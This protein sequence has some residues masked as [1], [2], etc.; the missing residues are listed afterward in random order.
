MKKAIIIAICSL[1]GLILLAIAF[2]WGV[3]LYLTPDR[4]SS[5]INREMSGY[6]NADIKV[7]N[8]RFT[9]WSTF[10]R[11]T[12]E[13]DSVT[14]VS[15][16]LDSLPE[17]MT[18]KLPAD[19][20]HLASAR[21]MHGGINILRLLKGEYVMKDLEV[22]ELA[23]NIVAVN[24]SVNNYDILPH[25]DTEAKVPFFTTNLLSF[26]KTKGIK[27]YFAQ[28]DTHGEIAL[29]SVVMRRLETET[30]YDLSL[31]GK[32]SANIAGLTL[33]RNMPF[34]VDGNLNLDFKPFEI[35]FSDFDIDLKSVKSRLNMSVDLEGNTKINQLDYHISAVNLM[36]L[37]ESLPWLPLGNMESLSA[38]MSVE[39]TARLD[40]PYTFKSGELPWV[41]VSFDVPSGNIEYLAD[42][43]RKII[44][45]HDRMLA[46]F[47]F[48]GDNPKLSTVLLE[49]FTLRSEGAVLTVRGEMTDLLSSPKVNLKAE[50]S[51]A[52]KSLAVRFPEF[53]NMQLD[54][55]MKFDADAAFSLPS[56]SLKDLREGVKDLS[57]QAE[58]DVEN[59]HYAYNGYEIAAGQFH[60][61]AST[62]RV[63]SPLEAAGGIPVEF[64]AEAD[65]ASFKSSIGTLANASLDIKADM[66]LNHHTLADG[67]VRS[68]G[69]I[70]F[71]VK[72]GAANISGGIDGLSFTTGSLQLE[73]KS[74]GRAPSVG[75]LLSQPVYLSANAKGASVATDKFSCVSPSLKAS[76]SIRQDNGQINLDGPLSVEATD[77]TLN[78]SGKNRLALNKASAVFGEMPAKKGKG[79]TAAT[80]FLKIKADSGLLETALNDYANPISDVDIFYTPDSLAINN[81]GIRCKSSRADI[82]ATVV[83]L[84]DF[85][86]SDMKSPLRGNIDI[87]CD[88][89]NINQIART[90]YREHDARHGDTASSLPDTVPI[91]IPQNIDLNLS[92]SAKESVYTNLHLYNLDGRMK[93]GQGKVDVEN[94]S[95]DADFGHA[96]FALAYDTYNPQNMTLSANADLSDINVVEFFKKFHTLEL[97]MPEMSNLNGIVDLSLDANLLLFPDMYINMPSLRADIDLKGRELSL[98]QSDFIHRLARK[99][100]IRDKNNLA[101]KDVDIK[102]TVH[103]NLLELY[104][105]TLDVENYEL[106][107]LGTNNFDG[108]LYY[109]IAVDKS[110]VPFRFG[111]DVEGNFRNPK[112]R[113]GSARF[114]SRKGERITLDNEGAP[115]MNLVKEAKFFAREFVRKAAESKDE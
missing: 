36:R 29:D 93:V 88:T 56:L 78:F 25:T 38:D 48:N 111:V 74:K 106:R 19:A 10:P 108:D 89:I 46:D 104:P 22:A 71:D 12:L 91:L 24:D 42:D 87:A 114:N 33:L 2:L 60:L 94:F 115:Q 26:K 35:R 110:P 85:I 6:F 90:Y 81:L 23:L 100:F 17:A 63:D 5:I 105:F 69:N 59:A 72:A 8:P 84:D 9:F 16:T 66:A 39:V 65:N 75:A 86:R 51:T 92:F 28:T 18:K 7:A 58:A 107:A 67:I 97:M 70:A 95:I 57:L 112:I 37:L 34:A 101:I 11:F 62:G 13:T 52:L 99:L 44:V 4:L 30:D 54:G 76:A 96:D 80:P 82:K 20:K 109:H 43:G 15:R 32:I 68:L 45:S 64:T 27:V 73:I 61:S 40:R 98:R 49:P 50:G 14:I 3:T 1:A 31:C 47:H 79:N 83:N 41:T 113:F 102:A 77:L 53:K 103:D 21:S 55:T